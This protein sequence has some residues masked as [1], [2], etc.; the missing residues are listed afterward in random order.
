MIPELSLG[1]RWHAAPPGELFQ[2]T[3]DEAKYR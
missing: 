2:A 1:V 3:I